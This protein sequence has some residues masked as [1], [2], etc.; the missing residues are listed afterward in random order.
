MTL[1][2][3][4]STFH[5]RK[6]QCGTPAAHGTCQGTISKQ[7]HLP[8]GC[9]E[10]LLGKRMTFVVKRMDK[11]LQLVSL[12]SRRSPDY[13]GPSIYTNSWITEEAFSCRSPTSLGPRRQREEQL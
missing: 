11:G 12:R 10:W 1:R 13:Y 5:R 8:R 7:R 4:A 9:S 2:R 3:C 6:R